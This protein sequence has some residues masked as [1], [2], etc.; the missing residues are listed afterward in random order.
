VLATYRCV[1]YRG[2]VTY[3]GIGNGCNSYIG[4][5]SGF[6]YLLGKA[7]VQSGLVLIHTHTYTHT[8]THTDLHAHLL[9]KALVQSGLVLDAL[10]SIRVVAVWGWV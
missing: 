4:I 7:L 3:T 5:G 2:L 1:I 10:R 8:Y 9:R 6:N